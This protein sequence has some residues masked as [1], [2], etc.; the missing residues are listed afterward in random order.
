MDFNHESAES[1]VANGKRAMTRNIK[2]LIEL[3]KN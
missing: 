3:L 1:A 2:Q